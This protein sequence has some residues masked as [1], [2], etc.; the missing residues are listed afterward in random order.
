MSYWHPVTIRQYSYIYGKTGWQ[1][2][3]ILFNRLQ[4]NVHVYMT[5]NMYRNSIALQRAQWHSR[6]HHENNVYIYI[7]LDNTSLW[8]NQYTY[9]N[10]DIFTISCHT[11]QCTSIWRETQICRYIVKSLKTNKTII[12]L[13]LKKTEDNETGLKSN[14]LMIRSQAIHSDIKLWLKLNSTKYYT[15]PLIYLDAFTKLTRGTTFVHN[16]RNSF[17][18]NK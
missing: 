5:T 16:S 1:N 9:R 2:T 3:W 8:H 14:T 6:I 12:T 15:F 13:R 17:H 18:G 7:T 11:K 4:I 10:R